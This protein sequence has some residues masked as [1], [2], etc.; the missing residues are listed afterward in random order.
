MTEI[1]KMTAAERKALMADLAKQEK[2]EKAQR[3]DDI[4]AYKKLVDELVMKQAPE[5]ADF[6]TMQNI[7]VE[8]TFKAFGQALEIKKELFG[9]NDTQASHTFSSRDGMGSIVIGYNEIIGFDGTE[10]AG[11]IKI[12][13]YMTS[14]AADDP[15]R[16]ILIRFLETFMKPNKKG[17]LNPT[18]IVELVG[19]KQEAD[20]EGF[21]EGVDIIVNAQFKTRTTTYVKG[22]FKRQ[23]G[24]GKELKMEFTIS[25]K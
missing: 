3:A 18:R 5:L 10:N 22:W 21:S 25:T 16:K 11:V 2:A 24:E 14:L 4:D 20:D 9:Y 17:E 6:G 23:D 1:T 15:K 12:R 7:K 19:L 13:E 8:E